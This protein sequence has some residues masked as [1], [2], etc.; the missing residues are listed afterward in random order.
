MIKDGYNG[1]IFQDGNE[2]SL[3]KSLLRVCG[4]SEYLKTLK[5]NAKKTIVDE[6]NPDIA[7][8]RFI[9]ICTNLKSNRKYKILGVELLKRI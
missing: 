2:K 4:N 7:A 9:D 6:W 8:K 5:N 3:C 1:L